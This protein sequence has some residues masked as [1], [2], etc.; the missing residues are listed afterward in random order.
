MSRKMKLL[1]LARVPSVA[2][3]VVYIFFAIGNTPQGTARR[4]LHQRTEHVGSVLV[5]GR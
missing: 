3:F 4:H 1:F 5:G 2:V